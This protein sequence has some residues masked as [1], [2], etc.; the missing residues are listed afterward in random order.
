MPCHASHTRDVDA[1]VDLVR[2]GELRPS[3][4]ADCCLRE[5]IAGCADAAPTERTP[6]AECAE[7]L[8]QH[9]ESAAS[10]G[11]AELV[12]PAQPSRAA[13]E[14]N[15]CSGGITAVRL[16]RGRPVC[17]FQPAGLRPSR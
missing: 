15:D 4:P 5:L 9:F 11:G 1:A 16:A 12:N 6:L 3:V 17:C 10:F 13:I 8:A 2:R 14:L 7:R